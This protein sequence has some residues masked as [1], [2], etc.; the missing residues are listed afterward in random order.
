MMLLFLPLLG[1]LGLASNQSYSESQKSFTECASKLHKTDAN[2]AEIIECLAHSTNLTALW[3]ETLWRMELLERL[4]DKL[5]AEQPPDKY[6]H[7]PYENIDDVMAI[8]GN[9]SELDCQRKRH[10]M[11]AVRRKLFWH[12]Q[13]S[14]TPSTLFAWPWPTKHLRPA[15]DPMDPPENDISPESLDPVRCALLDAIQ[16]P[17]PHA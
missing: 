11:Q 3:E 10:V 5:H 1:L 9:M 6:H 12:S 16:K 14:G 7:T 13:M 17:R 2:Y 8:K 15:R 4:L